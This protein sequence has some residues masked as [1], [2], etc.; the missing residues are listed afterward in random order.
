[1]YCTLCRVARNAN[2]DDTIPTLNNLNVHRKLLPASDDDENL[3]SSSSINVSQENSRQETSKGG[4]VEE[5]PDV[6]HPAGIILKKSGYYTIP[7][8]EELATMVDDDGNCFVENFTIG[9]EGYGNVY[10]PGITNVANL[11]L[12]YIG[13]GSKYSNELVLENEFIAEN[14]MFVM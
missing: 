11:N 9:R 6:P 3:D 1:M 2:L 14:I 4:D 12:D 13:D 10:F 5:E 8:L 7:S